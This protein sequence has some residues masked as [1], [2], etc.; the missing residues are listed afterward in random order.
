MKLS[1]SSMLV[2]RKADLEIRAPA[3]PAGFIGHT[4]NQSFQRT[5]PLTRPKNQCAILDYL[6]AFCL[7]ALLAVLWLGTL[8]VRAAEP[9]LVIDREAGRV[10]AISFTGFSGEVLSTLKFDLEIVGFT[11]AS[12][13]HAQYLISGR[14]EGH[15]EGQV[16]DRYN[17][18]IVL[19]K[20][21]TGGT[22]RSQAH[23]L[24]DDIVFALRAVKGIAQ[25]KIAFKVAAGDTS[26]IYVADYDGHNAI[27][28]TR[29]R[30]I[31]AAPCWVPGRRMLYYTS[32]KLGNPDIYSHD[33]ATGARKIVARYTGL[34]TSAAVSPDGRRVAMILSKG[35]SPDVYV[36]APDGSNLKQLTHTREDESS[37]CWSPDGQTVCFVSRQTGRAAIYTIPVN[38]GAM[39]RLRTDGVSG[40]TEPDWSPD[41]K[42]I[43]FTTT[44]GGFNICVAPVRGGEAQVL[45]AGQDPSWAPN[46]RTVIFSRGVRNRRVLSL[47]DVP[48]KRVKDI[49]QISGS[50]S[51]PSWAK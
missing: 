10:I 37:P 3:S 40:V 30:S 23:A 24:A 35:G 21:Y 12:P 46:S 29:D 9:P 14:N 22:L 38:G 16:T 34:N 28:V 4:Q 39:S 18:S 47:L 19:A 31:V 1:D 43:V 15:V 25:T 8:L 2:G 36:A 6:R 26:E 45:A 50:C 42:L 32:Y 48:T 11:N 49:A 13:D 20:A 51:Q 41:G 7:A 27:A 33:L 44:T 17:K 5:N